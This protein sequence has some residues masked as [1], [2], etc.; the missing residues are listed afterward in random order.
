MFTDSILLYMISK[1]SGYLQCT[2]VGVV[3]KDSH[4]VPD[5]LIE[6]DCDHVVWL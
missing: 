1:V 6:P 2:V 4:D 5:W 3:L